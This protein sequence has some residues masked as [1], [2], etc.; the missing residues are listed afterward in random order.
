MAKKLEARMPV[1][2][3][4]IPLCSGKKV[5]NTDNFVPLLYQTI[6]EM[7]A[8]KPGATGYKNAFS[9]I[10]ESGQGILQREKINSYAFTHSLAS[11]RTQ[12]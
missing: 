10:V 9:A 4:N 5:I 2:V 1:K 6:N 7:R 8:E 12:Q 3:L 11:A